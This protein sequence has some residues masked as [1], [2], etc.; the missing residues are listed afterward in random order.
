MSESSFR[1]VFHLFSQ[2]RSDE[3]QVSDFQFCLCW[4]HLTVGAS[5]SFS[6]NDGSVVV[7]RLFSQARSVEVQVS[8][9]VLFVLV[10]FDSRSI[11]ENV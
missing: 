11:W 4:L 9:S 8:D 10:T 2:A 7:F 1:V 6:G 3:L 5:E